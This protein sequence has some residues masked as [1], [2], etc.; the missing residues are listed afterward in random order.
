MSLK[1]ITLYSHSSGPNAWKVAIILE[2]LG[3]PFETKFLE[4]P[5]MKQDLFLSKN[6]NG[7][8]PAIFDPNSDIT[9]FEVN[10]RGTLR[11]E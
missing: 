2:E 8:V 9:L 5:E 7:R 10:K 4:F 1:P 6:P 11:Y 3:L